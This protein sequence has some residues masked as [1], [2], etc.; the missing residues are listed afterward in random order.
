MSSRS[1]YWAPAW[2]SGGHGFDSCRGLRIFLCPA[3]VSCRFIH[4]LLPNLNFIIFINLSLVLWIFLI[5]M[6]VSTRWETNTLGLKESFWAMQG[7]CLQ[8]LHTVR[9]YSAKV[10][11]F[12][13]NPYLSNVWASLWGI[14]WTGILGSGIS[15]KDSLYIPPFKCI[16]NNLISWKK[17]MYKKSC[18]LSIDNI[19]E[20]RIWKWKWQSFNIPRVPW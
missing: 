19:Q 1:G 8:T 10:C 3:L 4:I 17:N 2:C 18:K 13:N 6:C 5:L 14:G 11:N 15:S 7:D 9:S 12:E 20:F 16:R